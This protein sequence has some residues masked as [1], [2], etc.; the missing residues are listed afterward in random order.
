MGNRAN[1]N[2]LRINVNQTWRIQGFTT[3]K[4]VNMHLQLINY[5]KLNLQHT[6]PNIIVGALHLKLSNSYIYIFIPTYIHKFKRSR[7][8]RQKVTYK[9]RKEKRFTGS[10]LK[11]GRNKNMPT[12][13]S[14]QFLDRY[15]NLKIKIK[16]TLTKLHREILSYLLPNYKLKYCFVNLTSVMQCPE[17]L[18]GYLFFLIE[19]KKM[20]AFLLLGRVYLLYKKNKQEI[21]GYRVQ[22]KGKIKRFSL[23]TGILEQS[24]GLYSTNKLSNTI[25]YASNKVVLKNGVFGVKV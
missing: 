6:I 19:K 18:I 17:S 15:K 2:T 21:L 7:L 9:R 13:N 8:N 3:I 12:Y 11:V 1:P 25:R 5:I 16:D 23:K 20:P 4:N 22:I 14:S 24:F 10:G